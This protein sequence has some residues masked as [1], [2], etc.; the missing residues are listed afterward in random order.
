MLYGQVRFIQAT[1]ETRTKPSRCTSSTGMPS[2]RLFRRGRSG[3]IPSYTN[4]F[5]PRSGSAITFL[6][7]T[8]GLQWQYSHDGVFRDGPLSWSLLTTSG[9]PL[10]CPALV[11]SF[12]AAIMI[13]N[14]HDGF[15]TRLVPMASSPPPAQCQPDVPPTRPLSAST[16]TTL[17]IPTPEKRPA[18]TTLGHREKSYSLSSTGNT[19]ASIEEHAG[20]RPV[21]STPSESL[22]AYLTRPCTA[23][24]FS[25]G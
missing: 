19:L 24:L 25:N 17:N 2:L 8:K 7:L 16:A 6:L 13:S 11:H 22:L 5:E 15:Q 3:L 4:E 14:L 18:E 23:Q 21:R 20:H 9:L 12:E 1:L 10:C